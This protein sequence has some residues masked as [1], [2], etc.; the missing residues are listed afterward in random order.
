MGTGLILCGGSR[1]GLD[2]D[3]REFSK[4]MVFLTIVTSRMIMLPTQRGCTDLLKL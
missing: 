1:D 4:L 2:E 3:V